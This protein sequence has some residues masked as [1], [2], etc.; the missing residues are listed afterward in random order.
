MVHFLQAVLIFMGFTVKVQSY[1]EGFTIAKAATEVTTVKSKSKFN[2]QTEEGEFPGIV[3]WE[4]NFIFNQWG[5][6]KRFRFLFAI[7]DE[8]Y[9]SARVH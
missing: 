2:Y 6:V 4:V 3:S 9:M 8:W 1:P 5:D 7:E